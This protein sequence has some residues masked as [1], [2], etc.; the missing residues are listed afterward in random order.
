MSHTN[1]SPLT[2]RSAVLGLA[3]AALASAALPAAPANG[4][5]VL[6]L[7]PSLRS[8]SAKSGIKFGCAGAAPIAHPDAIML[9]KMSTEANIYIPEGHLKWDITEPRPNEFN[10]EGSDSIADYAARH[11]MIMHGHTLVWYAA[12]PDWV[13]QLATARDAK[14]ALE[15]HVDTLEKTILEVARSHEQMSA[16]AASA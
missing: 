7:L 1:G 5:F 9:E 16:E 12:N 2:R 3:S 10:F 13:S 4:D 11:D 15:R 14:A 6:E 8:R